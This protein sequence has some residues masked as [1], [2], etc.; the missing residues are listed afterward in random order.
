[1]PSP[2]L[3]SMICTL[4]A[5]LLLLSSDL[6]GAW[7]WNFP[8]YNGMPELESPANDSKGGDG[9]EI[10]QTKPS[11]PPT[12]S[13]T[14]REAPLEPR[15]TT[16]VPA[17]AT[18]EKNSSPES[19]SH[20]IPSQSDRSTSKGEQLVETAGKL[21]PFADARR[22]PETF[23][24]EDTL[25]EGKLKLDGWIT[26][27]PQATL[28]ISPGTTVR[29]SPGKGINLLGR[30]VIKGTSE[31]PV[32][33]SS[34]A[35][36][37]VPGG[38]RGIIITASEKKN[39]LEHVV[40]EGAE[41][42]IL[43]RFS[44]FTS[45]WLSVVRCEN[46]IQL[47]DSVATMNGGRIAENSSGIIAD[48]S[49]LTMKSISLERNRAGIAIVRSALIGSDV[50]MQ[51]NDGCGLNADD[52]Q[53]KLER[54]SVTSS[55]NGACL[56]RGEGTI[57]ASTFKENREA[58]AVLSGS[59]LRLSGNIFSGNRV[60]MQIADNLPALWNNALVNN[61]SYNILYMGDEPFYAGGNWFGEED[62]VKSEL[63]IFS[64]SPSLVRIEPLLKATPY[65]GK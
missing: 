39:S 51:D 5:S 34:L 10:Q 18:I 48:N 19:P 4:A 62:R 37:T 26:V 2:S 50:T 41:T 58:G 20:E 22:V 56:K 1:M 30:I 7:S 63:S 47:Q 52:S 60:G 35:L 17:Q 65:S 24:T 55:E 32:L 42:G 28:T 15:Q 27:A 36:N 31:M 40:L 21:A 11:L 64:K 44:S 25:W 54:L 9:S 53:L 3:R 46:G 49:E 33:I 43:A 13:A 23:Y 38:W 45:G 14:T 29:V 61:R 57:I 59:R 12:P 8:F 16:D 6:H